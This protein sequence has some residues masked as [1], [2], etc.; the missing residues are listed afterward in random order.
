MFNNKFQ[1][2]LNDFLYGGAIAANQFEGGYLELEGG[3]YYPS[4]EAIDCYY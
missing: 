2:L 4:H 1:G 3:T